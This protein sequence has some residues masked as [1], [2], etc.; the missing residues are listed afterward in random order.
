MPP[1]MVGAAIWLAA[2]LFSS[3][4]SHTP[5]YVKV[6]V[7]GF[8][9]VFFWIARIASGLKRVALADDALRISNY[10]NEVVVP[11]REVIRV[12]SR[13]GDWRTDG[14]VIVDLALDTDFGNRIAFAPTWRFFQ[15]GRHPIVDELRDVVT[16]AKRADM[17][18]YVANE[19]GRG[20]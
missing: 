11:L 5:V 2:I 3:S 9:A 15:F 20:P 14:V 19:P 6:I 4:S 7:M 10:R 17:A 16:A 12:E 18:N 8:I 13:G 1:F